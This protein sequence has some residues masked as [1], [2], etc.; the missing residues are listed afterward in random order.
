MDWGRTGLFWLWNSRFLWLQLPGTWKDGISFIEQENFYVSCE[1]IEQFTKKTKP[2]Y[3]EHNPLEQAR[4]IAN[5]NPNNF[6]DVGSFLSSKEMGDLSKQLSVSQ[7]KILIS[8]SWI[9]F[10]R[11]NWPQKRFSGHST[12]VIR[13]IVY[14]LW[15]NLGCLWCW[16]IKYTTS[17]GTQEN[18]WFLNNHKLALYIAITILMYLI[19][20]RLRLYIWSWSFKSL[21]KAKKQ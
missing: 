18:M 17:F 19:S 6:S 7:K 12:P 1:F 14:K 20:L 2:T 11:M 9:R 5:L 16:Q 8:L 13:R 21:V 15:K 4:V 10:K 3:V